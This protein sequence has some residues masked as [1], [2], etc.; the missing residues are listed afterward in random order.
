MGLYLEPDMARLLLGVTD[1]P[2]SFEMNNPEARIFMVEENLKHSVPSEGASREER[3]H[4]STQVRRLVHL[5]RDL[6]F[7]RWLS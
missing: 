4:G 3:G 7:A 5:H 6:R 2:F 1:C